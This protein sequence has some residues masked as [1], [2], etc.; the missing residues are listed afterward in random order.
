MIGRFTGDAGKR[1]FCRR[2][3]IPSDRFSAYIKRFKKETAFR[4]KRTIT[5]KVL[6]NA[7]NCRGLRS[8]VGNDRLG[9]ERRI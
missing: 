9:R 2:L 5:H 7:W 4:V 3:Q 8:S 6:Q 1:D